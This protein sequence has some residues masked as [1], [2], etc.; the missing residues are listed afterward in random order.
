MKK[1]YRITNYGAT[2]RFPYQGE[3]YEIPKNGS[4][5]TTDEQLAEEFAKFQF[6]DAAAVGQPVVKPSK[7]KKKKASKKKKKVATRKSK[8]TKRRKV[9]RSK[10]L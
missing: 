6:V 8:K 4:I 5:E 1:K 7:K 9:R 2:R 3:Y 10:K